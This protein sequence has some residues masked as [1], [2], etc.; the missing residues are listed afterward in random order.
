[1]IFPPVA[2]G[3]QEGNRRKKILENQTETLMLKKLTYF[4]WRSSTAQPVLMTLKMADHPHLNLKQVLR[5][6]RPGPC[7]LRTLQP[8]EGA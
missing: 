1:M 6:M 8:I 2:G 7:A 5:G 3:D 4:T